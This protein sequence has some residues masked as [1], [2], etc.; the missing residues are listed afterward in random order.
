MRAVKVKKTLTE[1]FKSQLIGKDKH[2]FVEGANTDGFV[3]WIALCIQSSGQMNCIQAF[4]FSQSI[5]MSRYRSFLGSLFIQQDGKQERRVKVRY[6]HK[7]KS[8]RSSFFVK[9]FKFLGAHHWLFVRPNGYNECPRSSFGQAGFA[10]FGFFDHP[11]NEACFPFAF[12][13]EHN[14]I[15]EVNDFAVGLGS[16]SSGFHRN[17]SLGDKVENFYREVA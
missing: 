15:A 14:T 3:I 16:G 4:A 11:F 13:R 2:V 17:S 1:S 6:K 10:S 8:I 12:H 5:I 9:S 7:L